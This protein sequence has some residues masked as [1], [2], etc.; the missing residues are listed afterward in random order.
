M[1]LLTMYQKKIK[2]ELREL[3]HYIEKHESSDKNL[4]SQLQNQV[5]KT[6]QEMVRLARLLEEHLEGTAWLFDDDK[7]DQKPK[8]K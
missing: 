8:P 4:K 5:I 1:V 2:T 7:G 6:K 3:E